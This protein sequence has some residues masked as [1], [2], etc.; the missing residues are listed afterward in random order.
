MSALCDSEVFRGGVSPLRLAYET[1]QI[2]ASASDGDVYLNFRIASKG[3]E[4]T[5]VCVKIGPGDF[6]SLVKSMSA[7]H[8]ANAMRVM[9]SELKRLRNPR[10]R[11]KPDS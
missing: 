5:H 2:F 11:H 9:S 3:G 4:F 7:S 6:R 1:S 8:R 10:R